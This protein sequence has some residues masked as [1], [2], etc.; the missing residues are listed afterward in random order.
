MVDLLW[1]FGL[2]CAICCYNGTWLYV[3]HLCLC[4]NFVSGVGAALFLGGSLNHDLYSYRE[5]CF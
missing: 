3:K 2:C 4:P 1:R 5:N